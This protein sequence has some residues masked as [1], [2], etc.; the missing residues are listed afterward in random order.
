MFL[1]DLLVVFAVT[2]LIQFTSY[3]LYNI[4]QL[5]RQ[6]SDDESPTYVQL[7]TGKKNAMA[8]GGH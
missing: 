8:E 3:L 4:N 2:M 1:A 5:I 6:E 7:V